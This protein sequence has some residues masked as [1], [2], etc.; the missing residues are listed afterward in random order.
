V[1]GDVGAP[2]GARHVLSL[3]AD[4]QRPGATS[5][6]ALC[7]LSGPEGGLDAQEEALARQRGFTPLSLGPRVLRADTAPLAALAWWGLASILPMS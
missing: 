6:D 1:S 3:E 4:A 7:L 2:A 5:S